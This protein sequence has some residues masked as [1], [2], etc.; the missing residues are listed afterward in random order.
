METT[1]IVGEYTI[2]IGRYDSNQYTV[3]RSSIKKWWQF[4]KATSHVTIGHFSLIQLPGCCGTCILTGVKIDVDERGRGIGKHIVGTA[5]QLA[6][7]AGYSNL[8]ATVNNLTQNM[9]NILQMHN[10]TA[11]NV[12]NNTKTNNEVTI[13]SINI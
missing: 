7:D 6:K 3:K 13:Y 2:T 5:I 10:F 8:I 11:V 9:H 12:Y 1:S 4:K